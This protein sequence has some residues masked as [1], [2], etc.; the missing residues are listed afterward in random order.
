MAKYEEALS[1]LGAGAPFFGRVYRDPFVSLLVV[2]NSFLAMFYGEFIVF[3]TQ[4][5]ELSH[6]WWRRER[7]FPRSLGQVSSLGS[8]GFLD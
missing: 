7:R 8:L 2:L 6:F 3:R 4:L 5:S 1:A